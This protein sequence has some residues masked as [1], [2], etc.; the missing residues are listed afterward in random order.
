MHLGAERR[1]LDGRGRAPRPQCRRTARPSAGLTGSPHSIASRRAST[2]HS[3]A[4]FEQECPGAVSSRFF[5]RSAKTSGACTPIASARP[6]ARATP[7]ADRSRGRGFEIALQRRP[8]GAAVAAHE[9]HPPYSGDAGAGFL[10]A[11]SSAWWSTGLTRWASK[12][13]SRVRARSSAWP[14]PVSATTRNA[15]PPARARKAWQTW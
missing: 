5:D 4:R 8:G 12:P 2:P 3:A 1:T 15:A 14:Q 13:A 9:V 11:R 6:G 10:I 7:R